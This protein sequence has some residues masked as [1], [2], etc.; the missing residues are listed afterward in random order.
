MLAVERKKEKKE[1]GKKE[2]RENR[3]VFTRVG[4][5]IFAPFR[6]IFLGAKLS[7]EQW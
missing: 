1:K 3:G 4:L 7:G 5:C 6:S 2:K